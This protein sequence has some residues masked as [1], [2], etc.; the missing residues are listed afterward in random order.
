MVMI[1]VRLPANPDQADADEDG[2]GD[3]CDDDLIMM[4]YLMR[5]IFVLTPREVLW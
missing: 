3:V 5:M 4:V 1:I 2:I